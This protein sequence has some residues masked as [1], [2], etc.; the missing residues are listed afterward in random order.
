MNTAAIER[1]FLEI[2]N[3]YMNANPKQAVKSFNEPRIISRRRTVVI[4]HR[5]PR[6]WFLT[7]ELLDWRFKTACGEYA[8]PLATYP[9][10]P[11]GIDPWLD[12]R[13]ARNLCR[14]LGGEPLEGPY[15]F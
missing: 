4:P 10:N 15:G 7:P 5:K 14:L 3:G 6:R 1:L 12:F 11:S 2:E 8:G 9:N 13:S